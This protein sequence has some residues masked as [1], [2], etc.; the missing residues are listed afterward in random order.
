MKAWEICKE[1]N[2]GKKFKDSNGNICE[3]VY[4]RK[5]NKTLYDIQVNN[6]PIWELYHLGEITELDFEEVIDWSKVPVDA[7]VLA[8]SELNK[9]WLKRHFAKYEDGKKYVFDGGYSSYTAENPKHDITS[10]KYVK[11]Y[12]GK[13][14]ILGNENM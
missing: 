1:E 4:M 7:K 5:P 6:N 10:Y 11:L 14:M 2:V 8:Y 12:D 3:V 13:E 9:V